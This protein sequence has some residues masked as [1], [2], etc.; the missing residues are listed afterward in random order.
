[1]LGSVEAKVD[2]DAPAVGQFCA[3]AAQALGARRVVVWRYTASSRLVAPVS[4]SAADPGEVRNLAYRWS[5]RSVEDIPPFDLALGG[6]TPVVVEAAQLQLQARWFARELVAESIWCHPLVVGRPIGILTIEPAPDPLLQELVAGAAATAASL[7]T[8]QRAKRGQ[9][10]AELLLE[11]IESAESH[12]GSLNELLAMVC[13]RLAREVGT[14]GAS[15]FLEDGGRL[16]PQMST[17]AEGARDAEM[18]SRFRLATEP[19]PVAEAAFAAGR[20]IIAENRHDARLRG[21]WAKAFDIHA[22]LAVPLGKPSSPGGVLTVESAVPRTFRTDQVRLVAAAGAMLGE[23]IER[24]QAAEAREARLATADLMRNLLKEALADPGL[25]RVTS[26]LAE[27]ARRTMGTPEAVVCVS[28]SGDEFIE[29]ARAGAGQLASPVPRSSPEGLRRPAQLASPVALDSVEGEFGDAARLLRQLGFSSGTV[30]PLVGEDSAS[31][32]LVCG[33]RV[34]R[35]SSARRLE[36]ASQLALEGGLVLEATRL[37]ELDRARQVELHHQ[38][39]HD[40]LTGLCNRSLFHDHLTAEID[41]ARSE[42]RILALLLIDLNRFKEINDTHGHQ[43]GDRVLVAFGS[44]LLASVRDG[45][46]VARLGGDEFAV[47]LSGRHSVQGVLTAARRI[48]ERLTHRLELGDA[49]VTIDASIGIAVFPAHGQDAAELLHNADASMYEAKREQAGVKV[50]EPSNGWITPPDLRRAIAERELL[51]HYQ[52]KVELSTGAVTSVEALVRWQHPV[53]GIVAPSEFIALAEATGDIRGIT[54]LVLRDA[55]QQ[56]RQ[57]QAKRLVLDVAVNVSARDV[58]DPDFAATVIA[59]LEDAQLKP[60]RLILELTETCALSNKEV[61]I[62]VL[63]SLRDLGV[64]IAVDDFGTGYSSPQ[65]LEDLPLDELKIDGSFLRADAIHRGRSMVPWLVSLG[66]EFGLTVVAE[67]VETALALQLAADAGCDQ[68]QGYH[69][70]RPLPAPQLQAWLAR[71]G[72]RPLSRRG[73]G[74]AR[75]GTA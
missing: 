62:R 39:T 66:H 4:G 31:G 24:A 42:G 75:T 70:S 65:V 33:D 25:E 61:A 12:S 3:L 45:D 48:G 1:M 71:R 55:L 30:I 41:R 7:L 73:P 26:M 54:S 28:R 20:P 9:A 44:H 22:A 46:F 51:L 35:R 74:L 67:G 11:L 63:G 23:M 8:W 47:V 53:R 15:I 57:W 36:L 14:T 32:V 6:G 60:D 40:P 10:Q 52:P 64:R 72:A 29:M 5:H 18:W 38:A 21:W 68:V 34:P 13:Q 59:A 50:Y 43:E 19:F 2:P 69:L 56:C 37:R 58:T 16:V 27:I 17:L 49:S